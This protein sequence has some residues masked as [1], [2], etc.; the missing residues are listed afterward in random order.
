[1]AVSAVGLK[2]QIWNNRLKSIFF[3]AFYPVVIAITCLPA[4]AIVL[5]FIEYELHNKSFAYISANFLPTLKPLV[6]HYWY[7]PYLIIAIRLIIIYWSHYN[8]L[9]IASDMTGINRTNLPKIYDILENLCIARGITVPY[10]I[11]C[12]NPSINAYSTGLTR[13][14]YSIVLTSALI[15]HMSNDEIEAVLANELV[16]ILN[17][18]TKLLY[19]IG[20]LGATFD[21]ISFTAIESLFSRNNSEDEFGGSSM[22]GLESAFPLFIT[23]LALKLVF[24]LGSAGLCLVRLFVS[25]KRDYI[26]DAG[27][28]E[29]T[30]NPY[31]MISALE[32]VHENG[33]GIYNDPMLQPLLL[34]YYNR[35]DFIAVH[36]K[37]EDRIDALK[38]INRLASQVDDATETDTSTASL[39]ID[40][41][42]EW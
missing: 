26:A 5:G 3:L 25:S 29:L 36:P 42:V 30:K 38:V 32:K 14:S 19:L 16:R 7:V 2:T 4:F 23:L 9:D 11:I 12:K 1:M 20:S 18:D 40:K 39:A 41:S 10:F 24:S 17:G 13:N 6:I 27:A 8:N 34:H 22:R 33:F 37:I 28:I 31:A 35:G 15:E 21:F